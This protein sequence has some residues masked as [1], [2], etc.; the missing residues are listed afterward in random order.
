MLPAELDLINKRID[1]LFRKQRGDTI[2]AIASYHEVCR[3][4][5]IRH[6]KKALLDSRIVEGAKRKQQEVEAMGLIN[7]DVLYG[8]PTYYKK[9][10][11]L[12][13]YESK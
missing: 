2:T 10:K 8:N 11:G 4:N 5:I 9:P 1:I 6:I 7:Y 3:F 12:L 13:N